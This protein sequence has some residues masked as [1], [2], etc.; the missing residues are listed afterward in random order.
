MAP[1]DTKIAKKIS[2]HQRAEKAAVS[3]RDYL[4]AD[5]HYQKGSKWHA[6]QDYKP[7]G[8]EYKKLVARVKRDKNWRSKKQ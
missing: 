7:G 1:R 6:Q 8:K 3:K 2:H 4:A 5:R